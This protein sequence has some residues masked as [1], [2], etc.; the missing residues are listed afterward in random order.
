MSEHPPINSKHRSNSSVSG[1][2]PLSWTP[3]TTQ[4]FSGPHASSS[5]G[6]QVAVSPTLRI[7]PMP[8]ARRRSGLLAWPRL[9][10]YM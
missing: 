4:T 9:P 3:W 5:P 8:R 2:I 7:R 10:R 1:S 6:C